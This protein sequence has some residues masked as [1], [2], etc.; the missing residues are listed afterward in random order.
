MISASKFLNRVFLNELKY[1]NSSSGQSAASIVILRD[2]S[3]STLFDLEQT[4]LVFRG[5]RRPSF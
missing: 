2:A 3:P 4:P 5:N 1:E